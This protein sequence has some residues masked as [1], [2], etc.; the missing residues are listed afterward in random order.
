M[1]VGKAL[2]FQTL[3]DVLVTEDRAIFTLSH[4]VSMNRELLL[5]LALRFTDPLTHIFTSRL[6]NLNEPLILR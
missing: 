5:Y 3:D 1:R 2:C 4:H 6:A